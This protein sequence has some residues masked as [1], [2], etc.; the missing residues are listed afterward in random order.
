VSFVLP[1]H[2]IMFWRRQPDY[3]PAPFFAMNSSGMG[4]DLVRIEA[5]LSR[6]ENFLPPFQWRKHFGGFRV[7]QF[8]NKE[9]IKI[10]TITLVLFLSTCHKWWRWHFAGGNIPHVWDLPNLRPTRKQPISAHS[11][12]SMDLDQPKVLRCAD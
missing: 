8:W 1:I 7:H 2:W 3:P 11:L 9:F 12:V 4:W 5:I 6:T 10:S